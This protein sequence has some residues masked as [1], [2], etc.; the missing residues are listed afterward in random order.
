[1]A[2]PPLLRR[3]PTFCETGFNAGHTASIFLLLGYHVHS[4][5]VAMNTYTPACSALLSR[6]WPDR[7]TLHV[8][9]SRQTLPQWTPAAK[10]DVIS[11]DGLHTQAAV[12]SDVLAF[13][14]VARHGATLLVD[15]T[16][17][18]YFQLMT[19]LHALHNEKVISAPQCTDLGNVQTNRGMRPKHFCH[20]TLMRGAS[21]SSAAGA[22]ATARSPSKHGGF[23]RMIS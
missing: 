13:T 20:S 11:V 8:G 6:V 22:V 19:P 7:F 5:D 12:R 18:N 21:S 10:C 4:F 3:P 14:R 23:M 15:D 2:S 17:P 16:S 9:D 1:M